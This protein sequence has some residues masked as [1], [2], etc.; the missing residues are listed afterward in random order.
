VSIEQ[1]T[2]ELTAMLAHANAVFLLSG[3]RDVFALAR[4]AIGDRLERAASG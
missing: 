1:L 3:N 2:F 4:E